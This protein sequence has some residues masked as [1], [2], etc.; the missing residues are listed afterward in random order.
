MAVAG[1]FRWCLWMVGCI[2]HGALATCKGTFVVKQ[3]SLLKLQTCISTILDPRQC[4][5]MPGSSLTSASNWARC[6]SSFSAY[7]WHFLFNVPEERLVP[8]RPFICTHTAPAAFDVSCEKLS[9]ASGRLFR[10]WP[11]TEPC[12]TKSGSIILSKVP[13]Q[14]FTH[15]KFSGSWHP[16]G[17][18]NGARR[19]RTPDAAA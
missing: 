13:N 8:R 7:H 5:A 14:Q 11:A 10:A 9:P 12:C 4:L 6:R 3:S 17:K 1:V 19:L 16:W 15:R 18:R 2:M